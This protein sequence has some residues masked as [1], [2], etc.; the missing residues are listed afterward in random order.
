MNIKHC[1]QHPL[2]TRWG[3]LGLALATWRWMSTLDFKTAYYDPRVDP[4][5]HDLERQRFIYVFWHEYIPYQL[6]LRG[7]C[8]IC[9]LLS[10]NKDANFLSVVRKLMGFD[11]IRGSTYSQP[12][13]AIRGSLRT[14]QKS[15]LT[16]TPDGPRGPRRVL[17]KGA[18]YLASRLQMPLILLGMGYDRPWR[19]SSWDRFAVPRPFSRARCVTSPPIVIPQASTAELESHRLHVQRLL[20]RLTSEAE[21]WAESGQ[22]VEGEWPTRRQG[23]RRSSVAGR[24][25]LDPALAPS[26]PLRHGTRDLAPSRSLMLG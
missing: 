21:R 8:N 3:G 14:G 15:H 22:R 25:D 17:A 7:N 24:R 20:N 6:Y 16:I 2:I 5:L 23:R 13:R 11:A 4:A 9:M 10:Q 1:M 19:L 12:V 18:I 26:P